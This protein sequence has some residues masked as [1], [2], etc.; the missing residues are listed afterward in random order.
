MYFPFSASSALLLFCVRCFMLGVNLVIQ[1]TPLSKG[2]CKIID[3]KFEATNS[4]KTIRCSQSQT[5]RKNK[6]DVIAPQN[7]QSKKPL[8]KDQLSGNRFGARAMGRGN[9]LEKR[10]RYRGENRGEKAQFTQSLVASDRLRMGARESPCQVKMPM[11]Q[12]ISPKCQLRRPVH[13]RPRSQM[14]QCLKIS[15]RLQQT[16]SW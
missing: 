3:S 6:R 10:E 15:A 13:C 7:E 9:R 5:C 4:F 16:L 2:S 12:V 1:G 14:D 8:W 11:M